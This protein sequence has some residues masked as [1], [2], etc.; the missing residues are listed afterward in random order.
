M[1]KKILIVDDDK[2]LVQTLEA[3]LRHNGYEVVKAY[4]GTEGLS[5]MLAEKPDLIILDVMMETDTAGFEI[6]NQIRSSRS[7]SRYAEFKEIPIVML[8]AINQVTNS[9]FSLDQNDS[10][11]PGIKDFLTKPI[12]IEELLRVIAKYFK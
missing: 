9:R 6:A 5:V 8:T 7:S 4:S 1:A 12:K 10:F 2:D 11:L 3:A